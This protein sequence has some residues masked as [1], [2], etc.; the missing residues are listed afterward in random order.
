[1]NQYI[2]IL[3]LALIGLTSCS[4][5]MKDRN[6]GPIAR[7]NNDY[8]FASDIQDLVTTGL[9]AKDSI[10][11][12]RRLTEEWIMNKLLLNQA[13]TYLP[14]SLK[15]IEKQV[16]K[17]RSSLLIYQY[18]QNLLSQNLDTI[19]SKDEIESYYAENS[20]N[21]VLDSDLLRI[22]FIKVS[23]SAPQ[24]SNVRSWYRSNREESMQKLED[25]CKEYAEAYS[26]RGSKWLTVNELL[27]LAPLNIDNPSRY[28]DYNTNFETSDE[29]YHYFIHIDERKK[30][31]ETA[32]L[33]MVYKNI[34][35]VIMNKRKV[36]YIQDL[37]N[38]V[39]QEGF[40]RNQVEIY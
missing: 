29:M 13:E 8:F 28:L 23:T 11:I 38:T 25:Y 7:V 5:E 35:S 39:Y 34:R 19:V 12:V 16:E 9:P 15:N 20:S 10:E 36:E 33:E 27:S 6:E 18:K 17:Y 4:S 2:L 40:S 1:M 3:L 30:E 31:G 32:P 24:I 26:I 14:E 37:E 22:T 21:Y